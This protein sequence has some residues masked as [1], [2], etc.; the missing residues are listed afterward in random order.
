MET[1]EIDEGVTVP[2][3]ESPTGERI[4]GPARFEA[5]LIWYERRSGHSGIHNITRQARDVATAAEQVEP[6]SEGGTDLEIPAE[7]P[8]DYQE[9]RGLAN[10][11]ADKRGDTLNGRAETYLR[12]YLEGLRDG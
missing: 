12:E 10:D 7:L 9:L 5:P 11:V 2:A 6:E 8:E 1:I 3:F 4:D